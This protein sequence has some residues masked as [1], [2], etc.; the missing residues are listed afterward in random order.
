MT[1]VFLQPDGVATTAQGERQARAALHGGGANRPL[2]GRSGFRVDTASNILTATSTT[3]TLVPCS[4]WID[5][6]HATHQGMYGWA[7]D[8][9][10]TGSNIVAADA[11]YTRKDIVYIKINDSSAGDGSGLTTAP[12]EYRAGVAS[13]DPEATK[14]VLQAREFLVGTITVPQSG[15]GSP[16][17]VL[18]PARYVAAGAPLPVY[19]QTE[20]DALVAYDGLIV[21]RRDLTGRPLETYNGTAW[22][23]GPSAQGL[24]H[25]AIGTVGSGGFTSL[26]VVNNIPSFTFKAGRRYEITWD[27]HHQSS[28]AGDYIDMQIAT[29]ATT[30]SASLTTGLTVLRQ[31][32]FECPGINQLSPDIIKAPVTYAVDTTKQIKF[33]AQRASG[34]GTLSTTASA[35]VNILYQIHDVGAQL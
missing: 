12:V 30:D 2:G 34:T 6:G 11:T 24:V 35:N 25:Q 21:Q 15:G 27:G 26:T 28:V 19:S 31:K 18:N 16:T 5:P 14:A 29:C 17:V 3:W 23:P 8:A 32:T 1:I 20:R 4:A 13:A 7:T 22:G 33:A 10:V 9:N